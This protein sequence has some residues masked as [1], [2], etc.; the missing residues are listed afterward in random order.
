M[1]F[2]GS[3][4]CSEKGLEV[5]KRLQFP[6]FRGKGVHTKHYIKRKC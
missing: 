4:L 5:V 1:S 6:H 2:F 3:A